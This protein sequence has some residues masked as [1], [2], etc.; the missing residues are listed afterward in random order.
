MINKKYEFLNKKYEI[1]FVELSA[2]LTPN[3]A[4]RC[5]LKNC[6]SERIRQL[7]E[8]GRTDPTVGGE[9]AESNLIFIIINYPVTTVKK[10]SIH[11]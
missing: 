3:K 4:T 6:H 7:A 11:P 10:N 9:L 8:K 5:I 2:S 1:N